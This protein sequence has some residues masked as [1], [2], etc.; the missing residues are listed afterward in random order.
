MERFS[1]IE[2][3][4]GQPLSVYIV[5]VRAL[6]RSLDPRTSQP[7]LIKWFLEGLRDASI[8]SYVTQ[9]QPM[10]LDMEI[11]F[12][13]HH[14]IRQLCHDIN[15]IMTQLPIIPTKDQLAKRRSHPH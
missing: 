13:I 9:Q 1:H 2:L 7:F 6:A 14:H 12:V 10:T 11:M 5:Q 3:Q 4:E 8:N 15:E